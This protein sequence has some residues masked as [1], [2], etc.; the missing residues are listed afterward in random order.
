MSDTLWTSSDAVAAT[1]GETIASWSATGVSIDTRS[2]QAGDLFVALQDARDGH[3]FVSNAFEAGAAAALVSRDVPGAGGPLLLVEDV[4]GALEALGI[5]ARARS[6]AIRMAVT[7]SVGK[8]S[9]KEM[10]AQIFRAAGPA[11]WSV[12]SFNNHWGVPLTLARMPQ[13]T[14]RAIFEIG[15]STPGEIAPRSD[16]VRPHCAIVTKIAGVHLEGL[17]SVDAVAE[18]KAGIF[19]GL[20]AGGVAVLPHED[21]YLDLLKSRAEAAVSDAELLTFGRAN[22]ADARVIDYVQDGHDATALI[23]VLGTQVRVKLRAGGAHWA[24]NAAAALLASVGTAR[25]SADEAAEALSGFAPPPG[26]GLVMSLSLPGGGTATLVDDSYNAN[27]TSVRAALE[28]LSKRPAKRRLVALGEMGEL[29]PEAGRLHADLFQ[30][31]IDSGAQIAFLGGAEMRSLSTALPGTIQQHFQVK[32]FDLLN[33][34]KD[35]L[36]DGD[37]LLIKGSN[38]SGMVQ[39]A[40]ALRQWSAGTDRQVMENGGEHAVKDL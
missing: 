38:A 13:G 18:E 30:A 28:A 16:M 8:T 26:R 34:V 3:D 15:M 29:G 6:A 32:S 35:T 7:G 11:H 12:K 31:V 36:C 24:L 37:T 14:E 4:L 19:A 5:A 40:D 23:D 27:P 21:Q 25:L 17:G 10:L 2:L 1:G 9:V 22:D 39:L 20:E 33:Y